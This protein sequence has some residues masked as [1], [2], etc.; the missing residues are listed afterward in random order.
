M[1]ESSKTDFIREVI[2]SDLSSGKHQSIVTRFPPEPNGYLHLGHA[3]SICLNFGIAI[4]FPKATCHL[5]FD[6][7]NPEK[8]ETEYVEAIKNDVEWLGFSWGE[9]LFFASDY[10]DYF[11]DCAV[12]LIKNGLA[13]VDEETPE[14]NQTPPRQ[15]PNTRHPF[16]LPLPHTRGKPRS[17]HAHESWRLPRRNCRP[18]RKNRPHLLQHEHARSCNVSHHAPTSPQNWRQL[19]H[20]S[21][22]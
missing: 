16:P 14:G 8:E 5:R 17:I 22:V 3:K 7:T 6:D 10:F 11:Y 13:Y 12:H 1:S 9:N 19:V 18:T 4:E 21:H 15:Y 20:L 2:S